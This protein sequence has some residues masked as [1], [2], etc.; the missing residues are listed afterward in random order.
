MMRYASRGD[1]VGVLRA[2]ARVFS[3]R[4]SAREVSSEMVIRLRRAKTCSRRRR[5]RESEPAHRNRVRLNAYG[6]GGDDPIGESVY[7]HAGPELMM[8]SLLAR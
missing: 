1:F 5:R 8:Y 7:A 2:H 3:R 4:R 6:G